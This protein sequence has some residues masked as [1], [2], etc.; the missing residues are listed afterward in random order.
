[1]RL[2][3]LDKSPLQKGESATDALAQT[4]ELA[5][6]AER[7]GFH[8]FW[9]AEHHGMASLAS[10]SPEILIAHIAA[11]TSRIRV[12]SGGIMLQHYSAYKV[13][14]TFNMLSALA[15][16]RIDLGVGKA[17]GGFPFSTRAL[18]DGRDAARW[19]AFGEQVAQLD[20]YLNR[21]FE[22][23]VPTGAVATPIPPSSPERFLLGGSMDSAIL[24]AERGW[25]FVFAG[26]MNGDPALTAQSFEAYAKHGGRGTPLLAMLVLV[27]AGQ[28]EAE[29][30][31]T[32]LKGVRVRFANGHSVNLGN[33]EQAAEYAR[34]AGL[35]SYDVIDTRPGVLA[36]TPAQVH[37]EFEALQ[38]RFG[39]EEFIVETPP[40]PAA[41]RQ[42]SVELL[43]ERIARPSIQV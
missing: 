7:L 10:S 3:L 23:G 9:L 11:R 13:A 36:G 40:V 35:D 31:V 29:A 12:G 22:R 18:Q 1:M 21:A 30:R 42:R 16:G 17:P 15:P 20:T 5:R 28:G 26:H 24:A 39:V 43:G 4:V 32:G 38:Q 19:P 27:A 8:R 34:Q 25:R 41:V 14:E 6:T 2:S 33:R 37:R